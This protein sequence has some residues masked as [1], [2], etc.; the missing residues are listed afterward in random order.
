MVM[1]IGSDEYKNVYT[2]ML[3]HH[4]ATGGAAVNFTSC[5]GNVDGSETKSNIVSKN[6]FLHDR[7]LKCINV[8]RH[9][10]AFDEKKM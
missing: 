10:P 9:K 6:T 5:N 7:V 8:V 3:I 2:L 4:P 1:N